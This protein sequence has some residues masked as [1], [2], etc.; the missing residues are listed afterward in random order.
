[1]GQQF[2]VSNSFWNIC[3]ISFSWEK[4]MHLFCEAWILF[5]NF[6]ERLEYHGDGNLSYIHWEKTL[7]INPH[8]K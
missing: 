3:G 4:R 2:I 8:D 6:L 1:M 5:F 7:C